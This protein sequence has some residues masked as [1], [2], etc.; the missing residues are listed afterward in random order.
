MFSRSASLKSDLLGAPLH[1]SLV[2][3]GFSAKAARKSPLLPALAVKSSS[4]AL[5]HLWMVCPYMPQVYLCLNWVHSNIF[6][7]S[8]NLFACVKRM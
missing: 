6:Q 3:Q 1:T 2:E 5:G 4:Q 8:L 7:G